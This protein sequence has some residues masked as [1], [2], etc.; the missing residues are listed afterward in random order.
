MT[1]LINIFIRRTQAGMSARI[2]RYNNQYESNH[3]QW[4]PNP[5]KHLTKNFKLSK[6]Q[7][8]E[9]KRKIAEN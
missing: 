7:Y 6:I 1:W 2:F 4:Q 8:R 3:P 5:F 9:V